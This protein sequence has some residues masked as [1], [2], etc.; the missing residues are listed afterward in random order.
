MAKQSGIHQIKGKVGEMSYYKQSGVAA[1]LIRSI[2]QGLSAR[3]KTGDE[4]A[5]TRRNMSEFGLACRI[6]GALGG[7]VLPK[8]RPMFLT[9]SQSAIAKK[10]LELIKLDASTGVGWGTRGLTQ[11][12]FEEALLALNNRAKN[13]FTDYVTDVVI[14]PGTSSIPQAENINITLTLSQNL[15]DKLAAIG[16]SAVNVY[17]SVFQI[18]VGNY[19][20]KSGQY[21]ST[22]ARLRGSVS[23]NFAEGDTGTFGID[24][25][26]LRPTNPAT[27]PSYTQR[28]AGVVLVPVRVIN[29]NPYEMQEFATFQNFA[30]SPA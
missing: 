12:R 21:D 22:F 2:N 19:N 11:S 24:M 23:D 20:E 25:D 3:V 29:N 30:F 18:N 6:A 28:V 10:V 17:V 7:S 14:T 15:S 9:F 1:G 4:Y 13:P 16:C 5:N 8:W 26:Y 27:D